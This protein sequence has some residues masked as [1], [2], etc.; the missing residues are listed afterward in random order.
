[1]RLRTHTLRVSSE[2]LQGMWVRQ[3]RALEV[4]KN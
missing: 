3:H 2:K 4:N 1:M